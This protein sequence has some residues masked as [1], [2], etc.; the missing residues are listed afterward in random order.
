MTGCGEQCHPSHWYCCYPLLSVCFLLWSYCCGR[1]AR[2]VE[3]GCS[4]LPLV[5]DVELLVVYYD[6]TALA[7]VR[8]LVDFDYAEIEKVAVVGMMFDYFVAID[9][10]VVVVVAVVESVV[11]VFVVVAVLVTVVAAVAV[12]DGQK[13]CLASPLSPSRLH[14]PAL[15]LSTPPC[16]RKTHC[17]CRSW[18]SL[19]S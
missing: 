10:I 15:Q 13:P 2:S 18:T 6:E 11:W 7:V 8:K 12:V 4:P 19:I 17:S 1:A 16:L 5:A 14:H 3:E 9:E